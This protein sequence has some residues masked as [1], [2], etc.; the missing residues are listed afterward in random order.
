[1]NLGPF[2]LGVVHQ[3]EA[4]SAIALLPDESV[5]ALITDPPYS[6][7]G[8]FRGDRS[9]PTSEKYVQGGDSSGR[10]AGREFP[11]FEGDTR[12]QRGWAAWMSLVFAD[13]FR[14]LRRGAYAIAFI[15]WRML[16]AMT[17]ALQAGGFVWRGIVAWDK[18]LG[19]RAPHTGYARHQCEYVVW[20]T[21]GPCLHADGRGPFPGV[22]RATVRAEDK[23]HMAGKPTSVMRDLVRWTVPDAVV[24]DPF[25]GSGTTGV[26]CEI[27]RRKFL[28]F[29]I[30]AD[31]VL[32]ANERIR[33][34]ANG[35]TKSSVEA[36]TPDS[37]FGSE[38]AA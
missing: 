21:K 25:A 31:A 3:S 24:L 22:I 27:E 26:A 17:D 6:S 35:V 12:D 13:A 16:P 19:A 38:E 20:G 33:C 2:R 9:R 30:V 14:V 1:M 23:H 34:A 32:L 11:D 28:G 7:G 15:D 29:E 10:G 18:G 8:A 4:R 37:L 36:S 5:D